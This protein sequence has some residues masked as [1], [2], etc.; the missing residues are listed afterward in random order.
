MMNSKIITQQDLNDFFHY[1]NQTIPKTIDYM[2]LSNLC[3]TLYCTTDIL[4]KKFLS[5]E[6]D[7]ENLSYV[8]SKLSKEKDILSYPNTAS[9]Y[10]ASFHNTHDK[11]HWLEVMASVLKMGNK[12]DKEK[13][14]ILLRD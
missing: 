8:F 2:E 13:A 10:G 11:G 12:P 9:F 4:P 14:L 7:K 6:L 1:L 5:L 3:L